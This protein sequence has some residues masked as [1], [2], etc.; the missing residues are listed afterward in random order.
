MKQKEY[1][2]VLQKTI[3][4][5]E[6]QIATSLVFKHFEDDLVSD[7]HDGFSITLSLGEPHEKDFIKE[8]NKVYQ[9]APS[10]NIDI[11]CSD[12][13]SLKAINKILQESLRRRI[14]NL[15]LLP[16]SI[17][18]ESNF[19]SYTRNFN[20]ISQFVLNEVEIFWMKISRKNIETIIHRSS[21]IGRVIFHQCYLE[22][23]G[24]AFKDTI[25]YKI[26]HLGF[27]GS[28]ASQYSNWGD[29][30]EGFENIINAISNCSI[31]SSLKSL[32]LRLCQIC[33]KNIRPILE[34]YKIRKI[35]VSWNHKNEG[36]YYRLIL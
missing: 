33:G 6:V 25:D 20:K 8:F 31:K 13:Q 11:S 7:T 4:Q 19:D 3:A 32:D 2:V 17:F 34:R 28:G 22:T 5:R 36:K 9:T 1:Q 30:N 27:F 15:A 18:V 23:Q 24:L 10:F 16:S 21:G 29:S 12:P 14:R 26:Q 35:V